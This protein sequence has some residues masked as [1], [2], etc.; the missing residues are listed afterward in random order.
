[1]SDPITPLPRTRSRNKQT[2]S[3]KNCINFTLSFKSSSNFESLRCHHPRVSPSFLQEGSIVCA[4]E[5]SINKQGSMRGRK[6]RGRKRK[7]GEGLINQLSESILIEILSFLSTKDAV[8]TCVLAK[9]WRKLWTYVPSLSFNFDDFIPQGDLGYVEVQDYSEIFENFITSV[10]KFHRVSLSHGFRLVWLCDQAIDTCLDWIPSVINLKPRVL[11]LKVNTSL[12]NL[13]LPGCLFNCHFIEEL[14]IKIFT[15]NGVLF[16]YESIKLPLLKKLHLSYVRIDSYVL[17]DLL[18]G[19][20]KLEELEFEL[21]N[22]RFSELSSGTLKR[23]TVCDCNIKT[24]ICFSIPSL[25]D[26]R[27]DYLENKV[28]FKGMRSLVRAFVDFNAGN[29]KSSNDTH[30]KLLRGLA[31]VATLDFK[32]NGYNLADKLITLQHALEHCPTFNNLQTFTVA[33]PFIHVV[34]LITRF[35]QH[36]PNLQKLIVNH[37]ENSSSNKFH[38]YGSVDCGHIP[39][40]EIKCKKQYSDVTPLVEALRAHVKNIGEIRMVILKD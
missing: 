30:S 27:V 6:K 15:S 1:M 8:N 35:I 17:A 23:L 29:S 21:C 34:H 20:P 5:G 4:K 40:V 2:E 22:L 3:S 38:R 18:S 24:Q 13:I 28:S 12:H 36:M 7:T 37:D 16:D 11:S 26:L 25:L 10:L 14:E 32:L 19:C 31:N 33:G 39:L 9:S